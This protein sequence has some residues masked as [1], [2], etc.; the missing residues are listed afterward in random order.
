MPT[1]D[2]DDAPIAVSAGPPMVMRPAHLDLDHLPAFTAPPPTAAPTALAPFSAAAPAVER[3]SHLEPKPLTATAATATVSD[4]T[5]APPANLPTA[6]AAP[7]TA[8]GDPGQ[9]AH[10]A[11]AAPPPPSPPSATVEPIV[12]PA[13]P[14]WWAQMQRTRD[15]AAAKLQAAMDAQEQKIAAKTGHA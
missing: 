10:Q 14:E 15:E 3:P 1:P 13:E 12:A 2:P 6:G 9:Q 5:V 7:L 8:T 4:A 11:P